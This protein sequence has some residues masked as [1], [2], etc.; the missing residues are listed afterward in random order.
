MLQWL[1]IALLQMKVCNTYQ[2]LQNEIRQI[3]ISISRERNF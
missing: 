3:I 2:K 1:P